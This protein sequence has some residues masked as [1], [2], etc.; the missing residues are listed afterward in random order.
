MYSDQRLLSRKASTKL[1]MH[2]PNRLGRWSWNHILWYGWATLHFCWSGNLSYDVLYRTKERWFYVA[3]LNLLAFSPNDCV[4]GRG[5]PGLS[6]QT[7]RG[8]GGAFIVFVKYSPLKN[9]VILYSFSSTGA[10]RIHVQLTR[11]IL[12]WMAL[13]AGT[14][15]SLTHISSLPATS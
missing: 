7:A 9:G 2:L 5:C 11:K 15:S 13:R 12:L 3:L 10:T 6:G 4:L 8:D 1:N 14:S